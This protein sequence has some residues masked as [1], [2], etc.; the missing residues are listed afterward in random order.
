MMH[1]PD[2]V[3]P[4]YREAYIEVMDGPEHLERVKRLKKLGRSYTFADLIAAE[5]PP[6]I[7]IIVDLLTTGLT[8]LAGAPKLGKSW[9]ILAINY[10]VGIGGAVLGRYRVESRDVL[11]LALEDTPRRLKNRL[12]KIAATSTAAVRIFTAWKS[13]AEGLADLDAYLGENPCT[14][15]VAI[16]TL[17]RF[18]GASHGDDRYSEDYAFAAS[19]KAIADKYEVAIIAV[20]HV[21]KM[22][23]EDPMD[24]V[25]GTN[26]LN[27]GADATWILSRTR[28]E[29]DATLYVT[30]RDIE[31]QRLALTFDPACA[32]WTIIGDA[33]EYEQGKERR[34]VLDV[35][36]MGAARSTGEISRAI[37]KKEPATSYLLKKLADEGLV[38]SPKYGYWTRLT[39]QTTKT[40]NTESSELQGF[41]VFQ[42]LS[43]P[44]TS[45]ELPESD[46]F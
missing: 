6:P 34:Q 39:P 35:L 21:R 33:Q 37:G 4:E 25:S 44:V 8:I 7:W 40:P 30:G 26:G 24:M 31:E 11:Y 38:K 13:G 27:G 22:G 18:R 28:G 23:S 10:A 9:L 16:D 45:E 41:Q 3:R 5:F 20:H 15:L 46:L 32:S 2:E 43:P 1:V 17:A 36:P 29:A 42:G 19:I 14:K 12:E